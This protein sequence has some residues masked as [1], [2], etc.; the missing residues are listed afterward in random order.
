ATLNW[1]ATNAAN[2]LTLSATS[3][4]LAPGSSTTVTASVNA[5]ANS[6]SVG[7]YSDTIYFANTNNGAGNTSRGTTL[8]VNGAGTPFIGF[9]DDFGAFSAGNLVGQSNWSQVGALSTLPLQVSGGQVTIPPG[10]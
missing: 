10:Q 7:N 4:T 8:T 5:N 2:W 1:T 6:L 9:L 3:G